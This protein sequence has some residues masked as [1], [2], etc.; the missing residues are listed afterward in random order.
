[1]TELTLGSLGALFL[2]E[3][4][5]RLRKL[6]IDMLVGALGIGAPRNRVV[7]ASDQRRRI[8]CG[9]FF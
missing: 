9:L 5:A 6:T 3:V 1:M 7:L 2:Q 4:R 8:I